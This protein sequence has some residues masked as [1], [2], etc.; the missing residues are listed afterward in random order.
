MVGKIC[1]IWVA[2]TSYILYVQW[3]ILLSFD[4]TRVQAHKLF[5]DQE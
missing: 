2:E 3:Y 4:Q 5:L 1:D